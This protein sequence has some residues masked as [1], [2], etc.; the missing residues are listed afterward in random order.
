MG[1]LRSSRCCETTT[2]NDL[3]G[4]RPTIRRSLVPACPLLRLHSPP[5][6]NERQSSTLP[7]AQPSYIL[8]GHTSQ[9]HSVQ[10]ARKNT[11][12]LTGD[13]DGW[14]IYWKLETKRALAVWKAHDGAI[15]SAAEWAYDK[16]IT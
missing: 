16:V 2:L 4:A 15:L 9:I 10:F 5:M 7:P 8:R 13:A 11:R 14:V 1:A 3:T 12:L 6:A